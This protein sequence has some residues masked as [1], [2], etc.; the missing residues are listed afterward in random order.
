MLTELLNQQSAGQN[1]TSSADQKYLQVLGA[2]VVE[3][4]TFDEGRRV[5]LR[6][7]ETCNF[8]ASRDL[9]CKD[10]DLSS[11]AECKATCLF[12]M[13]AAASSCKLLT[14]ENTPDTTSEV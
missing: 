8:M 14:G 1:I 5:E 13:S 6:Q 11:P 10:L 3:D 12:M 2:S 4:V 9:F 7:A